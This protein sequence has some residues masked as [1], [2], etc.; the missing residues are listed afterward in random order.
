MQMILNCLQKLKQDVKSQPWNHCK[1]N[2]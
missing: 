1:R 2:C